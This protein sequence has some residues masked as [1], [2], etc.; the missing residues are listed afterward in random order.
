MSISFFIQKE[1]AYISRH[2][3]LPNAEYIQTTTHVINSYSLCNKIPHKSLPHDDI[4]AKLRIKSNNS[5]VIRCF[6]PNLLNVTFFRA[7]KT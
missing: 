6:L 3:D 2:I 1:F 5:Y 7:T 4:T